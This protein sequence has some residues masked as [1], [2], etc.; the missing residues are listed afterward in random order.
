MKILTVLRSSG[1]YRAE[2]VER[3]L[4]QCEAYAPGVPFVCLSDVPV[5]GRMSLRHDWPGWWSKLEM[6]RVQGPALYMDL[7][8]TICGDLGP[9]LEIAAT[10][11][12]TVLRDFNPHMRDV[13][14]SLMAW[15]GGMVS[16]YATFAADPARHMAANSSPRWHGDQ[17]FIE[18][19]ASTWGY[20]QDEIP[21]AVV[22][23]KKHCQSGV[24]AAARVVVFHGR[25]RPWEVT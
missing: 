17:G 12:F 14:S 16:L 2:H 15:S 8:T 11:P 13:Q 18:R 6:F 22:S 9:L 19:Q 1:D 5:P 23:Y 21:G 10:R 3:L 7:D 25:P 4:A 20:W 24:P